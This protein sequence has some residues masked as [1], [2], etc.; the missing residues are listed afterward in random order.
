ME[1][2]YAVAVRHVLASISLKFYLPRMEKRIKCILLGTLSLYT[3]M[4]SVSVGRKR[5]CEKF[6][7][8]MNI[9]NLVRA[10]QK[11][12]SPGVDSFRPFVEQPR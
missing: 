5:C 6:S 9:K 10:K 11:F 1:L 8:A 2:E 7:K 3:T 12:D 4:Q